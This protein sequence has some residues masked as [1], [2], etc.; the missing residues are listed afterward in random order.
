MHV[1]SFA[2]TDIGRVRDENQDDYL[3]NDELFLYVVADGL[4]GLKKGKEASRYTVQAVENYIREHYSQGN[5][6]PKEMIVR[7]LTAAGAG[8]P[9]AVGSGS[10][11]TV[12]AALFTKEKVLVAN[13]G[14]SPAYLLRRDEMSIL[15]KEHNLFSLLVEGGRLDPRKDRNHHS[16]HKLTAFVGMKGP[17][18]VHVAEFEPAEGD[19]LLLCSDGLTGMV[20]EHIIAETLRFENNLPRAARQLVQMA[21]HAGGHDNITLLLVD[22]ISMREELMD[23]GGNT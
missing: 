19:R 13:L 2:L 6:Q 14:D 7:A 3:I 15:T 17:L 5:S 4:G 9:Q 18:P 16:R 10:G 23:E 20:P 11:S 12:V 21:N 1:N 22:I 8:F